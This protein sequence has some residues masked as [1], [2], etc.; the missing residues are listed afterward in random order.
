LDKAGVVE[1][2]LQRHLEDLKTHKKP[3]SFSRNKKHNRLARKGE[4]TLMKEDILYSC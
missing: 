2:K 3:W 4:R 1:E